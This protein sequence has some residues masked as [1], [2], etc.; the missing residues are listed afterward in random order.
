MDIT[1]NV[2]VKRLDYQAILPFYAHTGDAGMDLFSIEDAIIE[3]GRR[4]IIPTGIALDIPFGY[5]GLVHP[6]SGMAFRHGITVMNAPG[7]IDS[8]Y[9]GEI[10]VCLLNTGPEDYMVYK[11]DRI[12]QIVFQAV[13]YGILTEVN[14]LS[15]SVRSVHGFGSTGV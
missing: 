13:S 8:G 9:R 14:H 10:K 7:T 15:D 1:L 4:G 3:P 12:A 6:R 11:G 5:V 2:L